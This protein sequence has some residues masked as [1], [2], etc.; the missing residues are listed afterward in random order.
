MKFSKKISI[1]LLLTALLLGTYFRFKNIG[2]D[3]VFNY[4]S[5]RDML[6]IRNIVIN[7]KPT[8]IGPTTG[9]EGVFVGPAF[10]YIMAIPFLLSGGDPLSGAILTAI[11]G[12]ATIF[13]GYVFIKKIF[14]SAFLSFAAAFLI[15][16]SPLLISYSRFPL[17]P[18]FFPF[19][20][21][22][23]YLLLYYIGLGKTKYLIPLCFILGLSFS[24]EMATAIFL[25]PTVFLFI[26]WNKIKI[27]LKTLALSAAVLFTTFLPQILF[28]LRHQFLMTNAL[29]RYLTTKESFGGSNTAFLKERIA[30]FFDN[31][32]TTL[33]VREQYIPGQSTIINLVIIIS[34]L[35][36]IYKS[37]SKN[38]DRLG[39][40]IFFVWI[41]VSLL[42]LLFYKNS[43][44]GWY[45]IPLYPAFAVLPAILFKSLNKFISIVILFVILFANSQMW[46]NPVPPDEKIR[47]VLLRDQIKAVDFV[48]KDTAANNFNAYVYVPYVIDYP[49]QYLWL[50]YGEK[51]YQKTP[52]N[53]QEKIFYLI[54]EPDYTQTDRRKDWLKQY[55]SQGT[56]ISKTEF[57]PQ[58]TVYKYERK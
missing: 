49:Y 21:I 55:E 50:W 10:Y 53:N 51:K 6:A 43:I 18:N 45:M 46:I 3:L 1:F 13:L 2:Y 12:I 36:I 16:F 52:S 23:F 44:W 39:Y 37:F 24:F 22:L 27:P 35:I 14:K 17:N 25:F 38:K 31:I 47:W 28:E 54:A 15:S 29:I 42:G 34:L 8:L 11:I 5:A 19:F 26:L 40:R 58:I 20:I 57:E 41:F 30:F 56:M 33:I 48:Y 4:D 7:H 32:K 9:I